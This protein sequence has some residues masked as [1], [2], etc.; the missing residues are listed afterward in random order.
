[1]RPGRRV[2]RPGVPSGATASEWPPRRSVIGSTQKKV[3]ILT[4][5]IAGRGR[6]LEVAFALAEALRRAGHEP[7]PAL[8]EG[9]GHATELGR[10]LARDHDRIVVVGGDGTLRETARGIADD[11]REE[12]ELGFVPLGNANVVAREL[13]I[14]LEPRRAIEVAIGGAPRELDTLRANGVFG[15]AMVGVGYDGRITRLVDAARRRRPFRGWYRVHGDSLYGA[16]G[17]LALF[18]P[19]VRFSLEC[20]GVAAPRTYAAAVVSNLETYAKG[21]AVTPGADASDGQLDWV[22]RC[23]GRFDREVAALK[24]ARAR[25]RLP[26]RSADYGRG[27]RVRIAGEGPLT[28]QLDGDPM[29]PAAEIEVEIGPRVRVIAPAPAHRSV[30]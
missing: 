16:L 24:A 22:G 26:P 9:P 29:P 21:W 14:P 18:Q 4:N 23:S 6:G 13:G 28:W 20:D 3:A 25:R 30:R 11:R 8:T 15:L 19:S 7:R 17:A 12:V 5:P 1:M 27:R 10:A 2:A